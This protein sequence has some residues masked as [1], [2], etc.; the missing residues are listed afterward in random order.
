MSIRI[1]ELGGRL[2][3]GNFDL[4]ESGDRSPS[5]EPIYST[6]GKRLNTRDFRYRKK[7]EDERHEL[8]MKCRQ[9]NPEFK[10]PAD[11]RPPEMKILDRINIPQ[12]KL[13]LSRVNFEANW[14]FRGIPAR[15]FHRTHHWSSR[16]HTQEDGA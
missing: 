14:F 10:A 13:Q 11:Y 2:R 5:P 6:D 7:L 3:T 16:Q 12:G 4:A 1:D 9:M 15:E 8:V